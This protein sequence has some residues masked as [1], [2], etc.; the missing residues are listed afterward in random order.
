MN[1]EKISLELNKSELQALFELLNSC[2]PPVGDKRSYFMAVF[3]MKKVYIR[4]TTRL[5]NP[6]STGKN[7]KLSLHIAEGIALNEMLHGADPRL[8][9]NDYNR[10]LIMKIHKIINQKLA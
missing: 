3:I 4:I 1:T 8:A 9:W 2:D 5:L 6:P 7:T 10:N